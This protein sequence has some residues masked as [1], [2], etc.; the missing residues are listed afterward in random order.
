M[1]NNANGRLVS[2]LIMNQFKPTESTAWIATIIGMFVL[3][4][5]FGF[6]FGY[7]VRGDATP[8][9]IIIEKCSR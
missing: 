5:L 3:A 7:L 9:P 4:G 6:A 2:T 8:A 1:Y